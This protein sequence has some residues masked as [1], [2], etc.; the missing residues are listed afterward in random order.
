[1]HHTI[2]QCNTLWDFFRY[3]RELVYRPLIITP[4]RMKRRLSC[5]YKVTIMGR[6]ELSIV[7]CTSPTHLLREAGRI[8]LL[9]RNI[10]N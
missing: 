6:W 1:M 8:T 7:Q 2:V 5:V 3:M 9:H 4:I 10:N